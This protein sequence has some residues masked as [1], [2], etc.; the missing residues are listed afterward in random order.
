VV[1]VLPGAPLPNVPVV[2]PL[3]G[4]PLVDPAP[5]DDEGG[6]LIE[7]L[8]VLEPV[9]PMVEPLAVLEPT[10]PIVDDGVLTLE[11]LVLPG[12]QFSELVLPVEGA[13]MGEP[14]V[15]LP[16]VVGEP[17]VPGLEGLVGPADVPPMPPAA[18]PV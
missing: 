3:P 6:Q 5:L 10:L 4:V 17:I 8:E 11:E 13:P 1:P 2:L 14:G 7:L 16:G 12:G 9:L 15:T 18:P